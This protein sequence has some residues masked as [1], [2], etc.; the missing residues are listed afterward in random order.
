MWCG[1][2]W[3]SVGRCWASGALEVERWWVDRGGGGAGGTVWPEGWD[4]RGVWKVWGMRNSPC[5]GGWGVSW[6]FPW[7]WGQVEE[8]WWCSERVRAPSGIAKVGKKGKYNYLENLKIKLVK[9]MLLFF[10]CFLVENIKQIQKSVSAFHLA[11]TSLFL[12]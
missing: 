3:W 8:G 5:G 9:V 11:L 2:V 12:M 1:K 6:G 10:F 7:E 4:G